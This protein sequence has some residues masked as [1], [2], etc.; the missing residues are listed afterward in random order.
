MLVSGSRP[1]ISPTK[2]KNTRLLHSYRD[3]PSWGDKGMKKR[4][5]QREIWDWVI[6]ALSGRNYSTQEAQPVCYIQ[7]NMEEGYFTQLNKEVGLLH[8]S[9][10]GGRVYGPQLDKTDRFRL[11]RR[12][13]W[14][15]AVSLRVLNI[16]GRKLW[17]ASPADTVN[18]HTDRREGF[19]FPSGLRLESYL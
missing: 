14:R 2:N 17:Y 4:Q 18:I 9:K 8:T 19:S 11:H 15:G 13:L 3:R 16:S 7:L 1:S 6:W 5:T 12:T 10:Q